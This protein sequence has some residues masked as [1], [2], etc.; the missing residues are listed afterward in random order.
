MLRSTALRLHSY[1]IA[2]DYGFA[3]NPFYGFC[4]LATCKPKIRKTA[5]LGDWVVGTGSKARD[6]G[7]RL[8]YA[9]HVAEAMTFQQY[10]DDPRFLQK[11]PYLRGSKKQGFGDNI[12]HRGGKKWRQ[13]DSHHSLADGSPNV[14]NIDNDTQTDRFSSATISCTSAERGLLF[15]R[16]FVILTGS[17]SAQ[18]GAAT[19]TATRLRW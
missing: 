1:V 6:R 19:P 2:R 11:R 3:P 9:M 10:W 4:T 16:G 15:Q 5:D 8:V 7:D 12:Y 17:T 13:E 18:D 14:R